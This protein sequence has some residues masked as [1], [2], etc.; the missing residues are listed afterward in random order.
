MQQ[1]DILIDKIE[2]LGKVLGK[3]ISNFFDNLANGNIIELEQ[4][5][6]QQLDSELDIDIES[7]LQMNAHKLEKHFE[8]SLMSDNHFEMLSKYL[9]QLGQ[10]KKNQLEQNAIQNY[11]NTALILLNLA[12]SRSETFDFERMKFKKKIEKELRND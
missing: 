4:H 7:L 9:Y 1:R 10:F 8:S 12:D 6:N 11:F 3:I 2:Q 5:T